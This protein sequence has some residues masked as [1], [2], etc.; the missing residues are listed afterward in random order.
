MPPP[1]EMAE[2]T[3]EEIAAAEEVDPKSNSSIHYQYYASFARAKRDWK[4]PGLRKDQRDY[5]NKNFEMMEGRRAAAAIFRRYNE[6]LYDKHQLNTALKL[7]W[8]KDRRTAKA[9]KN[10][11]EAVVAARV[12]ANAEFRAEQDLPPDQGAAPRH[13]EE[14]GVTEEELTPSGKVPGTIITPEQ[15]DIVNSSFKSEEMRDKAF[16]L[17][18]SLENG[19]ITPEDFK[20][21]WNR[22]MVKERI[23]DGKAAKEQKKQKNKEKV[24][25][26]RAVQETDE[27]TPEEIAAAEE[28]EVET[29]EA[30]EAEEPVVADKENVRVTRV[31]EE[32]DTVADVQA[33]GTFTTDDQ[34][35]LE[36]NLSGDHAAAFEETEP[37]PEQI[38]AAEEG[39][40]ETGEAIEEDE[41]AQTVEKPSSEGDETD[42]RHPNYAYHRQEFETAYIKPVPAKNKAPTQTLEGNNIPSRLNRLGKHKPKKLRIRG[43]ASILNE[44][45][46][47]VVGSR[48]APN[49]GDANFIGNKA[50]KEGVVLI[51]GDA[52]G[53]DR[54]AMLGALHAGGKVVA[55]LPYGMNSFGNR[56]PKNIV[57]LYE[58]LINKGNLVLVSPFEDDMH[59]T[60]WRAMYRN[61]IIYALSDGAIVV[62]SVKGQ[63]GSWQGAVD[64]LKN[65]DVPLWAIVGNKD[66]FGGNLDLI[67]RGAKLLDTKKQPNIKSLLSKFGESDAPQQQG[68]IVE[69]L[70]ETA[71]EAGLQVNKGRYRPANNVLNA[72]YKKRYQAMVDKL[73]QEINENIHKLAT[74]EEVNEL[75]KNA[76]AY[77]YRYQKINQ[78]YD[79]LEKELEQLGVDH[80]EAVQTLATARA[81]VTKAK[82]ELEA[83]DADESNYYEHV[84][85]QE[86][87]EEA[88]NAFLS[89]KRRQ[90]RM[91]RD[92]EKRKAEKEK[93]IRDLQK[94]KKDVMGKLYKGFVHALMFDPKLVVESEKMEDVVVAADTPSEGE[95]LIAAD[96]EGFNEASLTKRQKHHYEETIEAAKYEAKQKGMSDE[97]IEQVEQRTKRIF[98][99]VASDFKQ[100]LNKVRDSEDMS[101]IYYTKLIKNR[102]LIS[103]NMLDQIELSKVNARR[104]ERQTAQIRN[105]L[106]EKR[107]EQRQLEKAGEDT[108]K[109]SAEISK[110]EKKLFEDRI[111]G[112]KRLQWLKTQFNLLVRRKINQQRLAERTKKQNE[113][114]KQN[115]LDYM[116]NTFFPDKKGTV[117]IKRYTEGVVVYDKDNRKNRHVIYLSDEDIGGDVA[118]L[119]ARAEEV[120]YGMLREKYEGVKY[121]EMKGRYSIPSFEDEYIEELILSGEESAFIIGQLNKAHTKLTRDK[122]GERDIK[123]FLNNMER[124]LGERFD[125]VLLSKG[126]QMYA[127][128]ELSEDVLNKINDATEIVFN[129][130]LMGL[131]GQQDGASEDAVTMARSEADR[132]KK[133]S[134]I[135]AKQKIHNDR[136]GLTDKS[137]ELS[138]E[139]AEKYKRHNDLVQRHRFVIDQIPLTRR[140]L[141]LVELHREALLKA[142]REDKEA[143]GK[144][145][146]EARQEL[147]NEEV[148]EMTLIFKIARWQDSYRV[149]E[150]EFK[151][152]MGMELTEEQKDSIDEVRKE[153]ME[154]YGLEKSQEEARKLANQAADDREYITKLR[155]WKLLKR[156]R[157]KRVWSDREKLGERIVIEDIPHGFRVRNMLEVGDAAV[158]EFFGDD[159]K[160]KAEAVRRTLLDQY[161][162]RQA[163]EAAENV[164][165]KIREYLREKYSQEDINQPKKEHLTE[166]FKAV[167]KKLGRNSAKYIRERYWKELAKSPLLP[168]FR[169]YLKDY[170]VDLN[171]AEE[172]KSATRAFIVGAS[173]RRVRGVAV[174]VRKQ[175]KEK[176]RQ[177]YQARLKKFI[178]DAEVRLKQEIADEPVA[179]DILG[180]M[181]LD[182]MRDMNMS[183]PE[184]AKTVAQVIRTIAKERN[185]GVGTIRKK[186]DEELAQRRYYSFGKAA[187]IVDY[188]YYKPK[189][190]K[191]DP[192]TKRPPQSVIEPKVDR[193][194]QRERRNTQSEISTMD[195]SMAEELGLSVI[196][197]DEVRY[198]REIIEPEEESES[199]SESKPPPE[200]DF[201]E[202]IYNDHNQVENVADP[203]WLI[204][205]PKTRREKAA[206]LVEAITNKIPGLKGKIT[207]I[208]DPVKDVSP[209]LTAAFVR[210]GRYPRSFYVPDSRANRRWMQANEDIQLDHIY[211]YVEGHNSLRHI[212]RNILHEI[213]HFGMKTLM[214]NK[215]MANTLGQ[216][217]RAAVNSDVMKIVKDQYT[218][219]DPRTTRGQMMLAYEYVAKIAENPLQDTKRWNRILAKIREVLR[220][221]GIVRDWTKND[222]KHFI[223]KQRRG[224]VG[225]RSPS[226]NTFH[227]LTDQELD[228]IMSPQTRAELQK[229]ARV[230]DKEYEARLVGDTDTRRETKERVK[231]ITDALPNDV[232]VNLD[233]PPIKRPDRKTLEA[234][235]ELGV[236]FREA[237][238]ID[239]NP[240][241]FEARAYKIQRLIDSVTGARALEITI[242]KEQKA[243]QASRESKLYK[244]FGIEDEGRMSWVVD[245]IDYAGRLLRQVRLSTV[246]VSD[247]RDYI[248]NPNSVVHKLTDMFGDYQNTQ[249]K[250]EFAVDPLVHEWSVWSRENKVEARLL[251][252]MMGSSTLSRANP[253]KPPR[254]EDDFYHHM[255]QRGVAV[256][257]DGSSWDEYLKDHAFTAAVYTKLSEKARYFYV[258]ASKAN[259]RM[260]NELF[261]Q[262]I[263]R[264]ER[265][266][267]SDAE[268]VR[269][270][271]QLLRDVHRLK[272]DPY[273]TLSRF[274]DYYGIMKEKYYDKE[275]KKYKYRIL[276]FQRFN[277]RRAMN[278]WMDAWDDSDLTDPENNKL[279]PLKGLYSKFDPAS[280]LSKVDPAFVKEVVAKV[281]EA[282]NIDANNR[283]HIATHEK[284]VEVVWHLYMETL[285]DSSGRKNQF[286]RKGT[287]GFTTDFLRSFADY[288]FRMSRTVARIQYDDQMDDLLK[289]LKQETSDI[290]NRDDRKRGDR[291]ARHVYDEFFKAVEF[292]KDPKDHP[293]V[294]VTGKLAFTY[295]LGS[296]GPIG[297]APSIANLFQAY[298]HG[299][300]IMAGE[301]TRTGITKS[302]SDVFRHLTSASN[303]LAGFGAIMHFKNLIG[304]ERKAMQE[305][306]LRGLMEQTRAADMQELQQGARD[307]KKWSSKVM[308]GLAWNFHTSEKYGRSVTALA[309]YRMARQRGMTHA[310]AIEQAFKLTKMTHFDYSNINRPRLLRKGWARAFTVLKTYGLFMTNRMVADFNTGLRNTPNISRAQ[311]QQAR[312]RFFGMLVMSF[313]TAGIRGTPL[314]FLTW[315]AGHGLF[316]D[317]PDDPIH[318]EAWTRSMLEDILGSAKLADIVWSGP[319]SELT[320]VDMASRLSLA[321]LFF[322]G[323]ERHR[324]WG[325]KFTYATEQMLGA[326]YAILLRGVGT[327]LGVWENPLFSDTYK[328]TDT[329]VALD[330]FS[331]NFVRAM[332]RTH[333]YFTRGLVSTGGKEIMSK[334]DLSTYEKLMAPWGF[335]PDKVSDEYT[336]FE[337]AATVEQKLALRAGELREHG[338]WLLDNYVDNPTSANLTNITKFFA[339]DGPLVKFNMTAYAR[340]QRQQKLAERR[341]KQMIAENALGEMIDIPGI[342]DIWLREIKQKAIQYP[343]GHQ[344]LQSRLAQDITAFG[345]RRPVD[346]FRVNPSL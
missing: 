153:A 139:M 231:K 143:F 236:D 210:N 338:R 255:K 239:Q 9:P 69:Q 42:I 241:S 91:A 281:E 31:D 340:F 225:A 326:V 4:T 211:V 35:N 331:P 256:N 111:R 329:Y 115:D 263:N 306:A 232:M 54:A 18:E 265:T 199:E 303:D 3:P 84:E 59:F 325:D 317:D 19:F 82:S 229:L 28:E 346:T 245:K 228:H 52:W 16:E 140:Q 21:N 159:A 29:G 158:Q 304:D 328:P 324:D 68:P 262:L 160:E 120:Q 301:D 51:S 183:R 121:E 279:I 20:I 224:L 166:A 112:M 248:K 26:Q 294:M 156:D 48:R 144:L 150:H 60:G 95:D 285:P 8:K 249:K 339:P 27:F 180:R 316:N 334:E 116:L 257:E 57:N 288:H 46:L 65:I 179:P 191:M 342:I 250:H 165:P 337:A 260:H 217:Y 172:L 320:G 90:E 184:I 230:D 119:M 79:A 100:R 108:A 145:S 192:G 243:H 124:E 269:R 242:D 148:E 122:F 163:E 266:S 137:R 292:A 99:M 205:D 114:R 97:E 195:E 253:T 33:E 203:A 204:A 247:L 189:R 170:E 98:F 37:T 17:Y 274:G 36:V 39:E 47:A 246:A 117:L 186:F 299:A 188:V 344:L 164:L 196:G 86:E 308:R 275:E 296:L 74:Q 147:I 109:L 214:T 251:D 135:R 61:K 295:Y 343:S 302:Y 134:T 10:V 127:H 49:V 75:V 70:S 22:L 234:L 72:E 66:D 123:A 85:A 185:E 1:E 207:L 264:V 270:K 105:D 136:E 169:Q 305:L 286:R 177:N 167:A 273:F 12:K 30:I 300:A 174:N 178:E 76:E 259:L 194:R 34:G 78:E 307:Y 142:G 130:T 336:R 58:I 38:A 162:G 345:G 77:A 237:S 125:E 327:G 182:Q 332:F 278:N 213:S 138:V 151:A 341:G 55:I 321:N 212:E 24:A 209:A 45:G 227:D 221:I 155:Q 129:D 15:R 261:L 258:E 132:E 168:E 13:L 335:T 7:A 56:M 104:L 44:S 311:R 25:A 280:A 323:S 333:A 6:G 23:A 93:N 2:P 175:N 106:R 238:I 161:A 101:L 226:A 149:N 81:K 187:D 309:S 63:G 87:F 282:F 318:V 32:G 173:R 43:D 40:V 283:D 128:V 293:L 223:L 198:G 89:I 71:E 254:G 297:S 252:E 235:N 102:V 298:T 284:I 92:A 83:P 276:G 319:V 94:A 50:A 244:V 271:D 240:D 272:A 315:A 208:T 141:D 62:H 64:S 152:I 190:T 290:E 313:L 80:R 200:L 291:W 126:D 176:A 171:D 268:K 154:H 41:A 67:K 201:N 118:N 322:M 267:A 310:D 11:R 287:P 220:Q 110:L 330:N 157:T 113:R 88:N 215:S 131:T 219:H 193:E 289:Q 233:E 103:N 53:T 216:I 202:S 146:P 197:E 218:Q 314:T 96:H 133:L 277:N 5:I 14:Q 312:R 206:G 73:Y 107:I 222:L 181:D